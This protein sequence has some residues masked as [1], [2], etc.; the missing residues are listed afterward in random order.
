MARQ[1]SP[2]IAPKDLS[3][4]WLGYFST[5][6]LWAISALL[7][8]E[9]QNSRQEQEKLQRLE[10]LR[11]TLVTAILTE[12]I[13]NAIEDLRRL[14]HSRAML[15]YLRSD[16]Y[17]NRRRLQMEFGNLVVHSRLY[18]QVRYLDN[19]GNER[20]RVNFSAGATEIVPNAKL[21]NKSDRYYFR[22]AITLTSGQIYL[23]PCDLNVEDGKIEI[24]YKPML[25]LAMPLFRNYGE[26]PAGILVLNYQASQLF[27]RFREVMQKSWGETMILNGEGFWLLSTTPAD[28][29]GFML[30]GHPLFSER[31]P[32][33]WQ[34][35]KAPSSGT[36][37]TPDGWYIF[38]TLNTGALSANAAR[39]ERPDLYTWKIL[40]HIKSEQLAFSPLAV[41][42]ARL[43]LA[44]ALVLASALLSLLL[45]WL[46]TYQIL[47]RRA[48]KISEARHRNLFEN[49]ADG[50]ALQ[51]A[52]YDDNGYPQDYRYLEVNPAFERVLGQP[53][54]K[55][56][57][58]KL[59]ELFPQVEPQWLDAFHQVAGNGKPVRLEQFDSRFDRHFELTATSSGPG[60]VAVFFSDITERRRAE[61]E[62]RQAA[63]VFNSTA[64]AIMVADANHDIVAINPAFSTITGYQAEEVLGKNP[65]HYKSGRHNS[66]FYQAI[67]DSVNR[68]GFWQ[69]EIWNRRKNGEIFPAWENISVVK[70]DAGE[71]QQYVA[72]MSDISPIK[73]AEE[74]LSRLAHQDILT[75]L[76]NRYLFSAHLEQAL[77]RAK[78]HQQK[79]ALLFLDLDRFKLINDTL[80]HTTGDQLLQEIGQRLK[81]CARAEDMVARLGGDEFTIIMEG[82]DHPEDAAVLARKIIAAT[83]EP[84]R[85]DTGEVVTSASVGISIFP[86]DADT[87][88]DLAKAAD[89]AM[90]RAKNK[91]RQ[92]YEFYTLDLTHQAESRML[93]EQDLRNAITNRE[94]ELYFQP[95]INVKSGRIVGVE[96]L[97]RW[98]HPKKG[99]LLPGQFIH[100]AEESGLIDAIGNWVLEQSCLQAQEWQRLQLQP[101][102]IGFNLSARQLMYE[103]IVDKIQQTLAAH[104]L[105]PKLLMW[106]LEITESMLVSGD[107]IPQALRRLQNIGISIAIDDFGTG[108]S[109]LSH[110]KHLPV[111]TLKIDRS[112]LRQIPADAD[113]NAITAAIIL[114]GHRLGLHVIAEGVETREQL[115]YLRDQGC[116]EAQGYLIGKPMPAAEI[117][118]ILKRGKAD[119]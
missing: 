33:A 106:Q 104:Q 28:E 114:M 111:D 1:L 52:I 117:L 24:P 86:N 22:D 115:Q 18:D 101:I 95:Q 48:L 37:K 34:M 50:Y 91:G 10:S 27:S 75:G 20:V 105:N 108:Y 16:Q 61:R 110:L 97:L 94:F 36:V 87:V 55:I 44:I 7:W 15:D 93:L 38:N 102:R 70:N 66:D 49:M 30:G 74:R 40:S 98:H 72:I 63:V 45:A 112:F 77:E 43:Y 92:G 54:S 89:A 23:S 25:R 84:V 39:S 12:D 53:R 8:F 65:R 78:R 118:P 21:Q 76:A 31:H 113:N 96:A 58:K 109:S 11:L 13:Q 100:I 46:R 42:H 103:E 85:L 60:L 56:I 4:R 51:E 64:E 73:A 80:G 29:W 35:I 2:R 90:Y 107:R 69:G 119:A 81:H 68:N 6:T 14:A 41:L 82:I 17:D 67:W 3:W 79:V 83:S 57:G 47:S 116:D 99:M 59:S 32:Q 19:Q 5:L 9:F 71:F 88:D 62:L 26:A